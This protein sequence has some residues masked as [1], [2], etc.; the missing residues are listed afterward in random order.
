MPCNLFFPS[1]L[2]ALSLDSQCSHK[3]LA[4]RKAGGES[5]IFTTETEVQIHVYVS[6]LLLPLVTKSNN[7]TDH[8][9]EVVG[10]ITKQRGI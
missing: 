3:A 9:E 10:T 6:T 5:F 2:S 7:A 4:F 8:M 1:S